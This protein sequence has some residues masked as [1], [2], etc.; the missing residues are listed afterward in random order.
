MFRII[1]LAYVES[2]RKRA[3]LFLKRQRRNERLLEPL[4]ERETGVAFAMANLESG[5]LHLHSNA[6]VIAVLGMLRRISERIVVRRIGVDPFEVFGCFG[7]GQIETARSEC[8]S[9]R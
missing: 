9:Q 3:L 7:A 8:Q 4:I 1:R 2:H 5:L 6:M